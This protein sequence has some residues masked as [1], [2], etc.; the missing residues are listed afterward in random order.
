MTSEGELKLLGTETPEVTLVK[1]MHDLSTLST[2][3]KLMINFSNHVLGAGP[4]V[5][6]FL[7]VIC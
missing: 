4:F 2:A 1:C 6:Y 7:Q 3:P 5:L